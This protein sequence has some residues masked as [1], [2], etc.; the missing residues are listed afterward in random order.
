MV[1]IGMKKGKENNHLK[2][3]AVGPKRGEE[4]SAT[5]SEK[6]KHHGRICTD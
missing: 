6:E 5:T 4:V 3:R 1:S 2:E